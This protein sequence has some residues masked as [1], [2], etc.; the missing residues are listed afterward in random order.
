M[1]WIC[2]LFDDKIPLYFIYVHIKSF[3]IKFHTCPSDLD[4]S[5]QDTNLNYV[6]F[7]LFL[8]T[9]TQSVFQI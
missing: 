3:R 5:E 8:L 2:H 1:S 6:S 4:T 9:G 7:P